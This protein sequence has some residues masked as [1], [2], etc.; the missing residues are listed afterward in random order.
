MW[1]CLL[2][3][4]PRVGRKGGGTRRKWKKLVLERGK[5][6][7]KVERS[8]R[9]LLFYKERKKRGRNPRF[10]RCTLKG[11]NEG[12]VRFLF[13][14]RGKKKEK[15]KWNPSSPPG[16]GA[17]AQKVRERERADLILGGRRK[18]E[19]SSL[20]ILSSDTERR[21]RERAAPRPKV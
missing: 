10:C 20:L 4:A 3:A 9:L 5:K 1:D 8:S 6:S 19:R 17:D 11:E 18:K 21:T 14:P 16:V 13:M 2:C 12:S 15:K 7:G